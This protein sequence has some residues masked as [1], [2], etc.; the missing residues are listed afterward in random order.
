MGVFPLFVAI[1]LSKRKKIVPLFV[2]ISNF[3]CRNFRCSI[4][5][6]SKSFAPNFEKSGQSRK[7]QEKKEH[8]LVEN[9][10]SHKKKRFFPQQQ[11]VQE[12]NRAFFCKFQVG[13]I[14]EKVFSLV[15][16]RFFF[17]NFLV[18]KAFFERGSGFKQKEFIGENRLGIFQGF[19][20]LNFPQ[21]PY[22]SPRS[23][24]S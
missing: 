12:R 3:R 21:K 20:V 8:F 6:F 17:E 5:F 14:E 11:T 2:V 16:S 22:S 7:L 4:F 13:G 18:K 9:F 15:F 19:L 1:F 23:E 24:N 10:H